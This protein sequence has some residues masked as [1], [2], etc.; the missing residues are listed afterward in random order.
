MDVLKRHA[1]PAALA[2]ALCVALVGCSSFAPEEPPVPDSTLVQ[3]LVEMH[4]AEARRQV[5]GPIPPALR[6]SILM[7]H[8][9]DNTRLDAAMDFYS[10]RP[11]AYE[12]LYDIV[13]DSLKERD[14]ASSPSYRSQ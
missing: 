13:L 2:L 10:A 4:L 1:A 3:V 12:A 8:G 5:H 11:V 9:L 6:D 7:Q 14:P